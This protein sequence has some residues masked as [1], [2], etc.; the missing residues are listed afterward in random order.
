MK[1]SSLVESGG[2]NANFVK[3]A[4]IHDIGIFQGGRFESYIY[5]N[6]SIPILVFICFVQLQV[7]ILGL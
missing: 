7:K 2:N 3:L 5:T 6:P 1:F 4:E